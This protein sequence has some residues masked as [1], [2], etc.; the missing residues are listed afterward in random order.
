MQFTLAL[1][2]MVS[3]PSGWLLTLATLTGFGITEVSHGVSEIH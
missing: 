2:N 3:S 1:A